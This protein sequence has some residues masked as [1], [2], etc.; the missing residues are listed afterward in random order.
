MNKGAYN[1][2]GGSAELNEDV[3]ER[4]EED[5]GGGRTGAGDVQM[6]RDEKD[7]VCLCLCPIR[8]FVHSVSL[9]SGF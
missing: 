9:G 5:M 7:A 8:F 4:G 1:F 2:G 3:G 6:N